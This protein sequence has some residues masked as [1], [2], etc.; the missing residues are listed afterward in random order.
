MLKRSAKVWFMSFL[1]II[2]QESDAACLE[3]LWGE[4][5]TSL[6]GLIMDIIGGVF[7]LTQMG[8]KC[9][10]LLHLESLGV[11]Q[12]CITHKCT[13]IIRFQ[14]HPG[15][16]EGAETI[17]SSIE[18]SC[19]FVL[20][21]FH[22]PLH[23]TACPLCEK[24]TAWPFRIFWQLSKPSNTQCITKLAG[25]LGIFIV[26]ARMCT[27]KLKSLSM[28]WVWCH[29]ELN[30]SL[31][32]HQCSN[33]LHRCLA[34][35]LSTAYDENNRPTPLVIVAILNLRCKLQSPFSIGPTTVERMT[36]AIIQTPKCL[37]QAIPVLFSLDL[38]ATADSQ[39]RNSLHIFATWK[40]SIIFEAKTCLTICGRVWPIARVGDACQAFASILFSINEM[41]SLFI[42]LCFQA[43][44]VVVCRQK[45]KFMMHGSW[46]WYS[47]QRDID[48]WSWIDYYRSRCGCK[49]LTLMDSLIQGN[50]VMEMVCVDGTD[51]ILNLFTAHRL[52]LDIHW[53]WGV[54]EQG[55]KNHIVVTCTHEGWWTEYASRV[56]EYHCNYRCSWQAQHTLTAKEWHMYHQVLSNSNCKHKVHKQTLAA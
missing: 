35:A 13:S 46:G 27:V 26:A 37:V 53:Q 4:C 25:Y 12:P 15:P 11:T 32:L 50:T 16:S 28:T 38:S 14:I 29:I 51:T 48:W 23:L 40:Q 44:E 24:R 55:V 54:V 49:K 22:V 41:S 3:K 45:Q 52:I 33:N 17:E 5:H 31:T 9:S 1:S 47:T 30:Y 7:L 20:N 21:S 43:A 8:I 34:E 2:E 18:Q 19:H 6:Q 42:H 56:L 39:V 36:C 10:F